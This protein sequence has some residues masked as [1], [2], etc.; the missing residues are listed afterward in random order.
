MLGKVILAEFARAGDT[1]TAMA[2]V[3]VVMDR[4]ALLLGAE[5]VYG[6]SKAKDLIFDIEPGVFQT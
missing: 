2:A 3:G 1:L 6:P 4:E 5:G